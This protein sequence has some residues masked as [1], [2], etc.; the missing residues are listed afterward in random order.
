MKKT[1]KIT[2]AE[3]CQENWNKM[4]SVEKGKHCEVC[5]KN[6]VDFTGKSDEEIYK[7]VTKNNN[8]CGR[9]NKTQLNREIKLERKSAFNL[10]PYAAS[11]LLPLSLMQTISATPKNAS[12][13]EF[14]S[15]GIGKFSP[16]TSIRAQIITKGIVSDGNGN[17]LANVKIISNET[18]ASTWTATDGS[19]KIVTL[20]HEILTFSKSGFI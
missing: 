7:H 14:T 8:S 12:N 2:I 11:L 15:L 5:S 17:P 13:K 6:V 18:E 3:P 4:T 16:K 19:Y 9:F 20:D 10:L 1:I